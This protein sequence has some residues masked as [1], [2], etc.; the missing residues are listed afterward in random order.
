LDLN[1]DIFIVKKKS[2]DVHVDYCSLIKN[3]YKNFFDDKPNMLPKKKKP[4][5]VFD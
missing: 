5:D 3:I 2:L 1:L 4:K